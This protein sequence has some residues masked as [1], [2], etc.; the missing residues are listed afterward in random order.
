MRMFSAL[1]VVAD[2][3]LQIG[4]EDAV[5]DYQRIKKLMVRLL[6][7]RSDVIDGRNYRPWYSTKAGYKPMSVEIQRVGWYKT[8]GSL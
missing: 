4:F 5:Q 7:T 6:V 3:I 1:P 2:M 8:A